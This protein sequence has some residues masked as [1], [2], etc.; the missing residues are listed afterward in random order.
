MNGASIRLVGEVVGFQLIALEVVQLEFRAVGEP[1]NA[2]GD[3]RVFL[4]CPTDWSCSKAAIRPGAG[5]RPGPRHPRCD[6][7]QK[8]PPIYLFR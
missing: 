1:T 4:G 6:G 8:V 2:G 7:F 5:G 3:F